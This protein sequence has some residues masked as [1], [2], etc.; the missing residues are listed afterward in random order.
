MS[1]EKTHHADVYDDLNS[2][3]IFV[4]GGTGM[5]GSHVIQK[6][7]K[8]HKKV[9]AI[10]RNV[11][12]TYEGSQKVE[13]CKGDIL[14]IPFLEE[15][16]VNISTVYHCAAIVSFN[17]KNKRELFKIN[18]EGT[19][20]VVNAALLNGVN[21]MCHVS[22]VAALGKPK[23]KE[24][25]ETNDWNDADVKSN[26]SKSK[27]L[28]ELEVWRGI[29]EGMNAVIVNPSI[30]LGAG[31]WDSGSTKIFQ[32]AYNEFPWYTEGVTGFVD[33]HDVVDAMLQ[34]TQ[35]NVTNERFIVSAENKTYQ[36]IF[37]SIATNFG[38]KSPH[39]K[40]TPLLAGVIRRLED[41]KSIFSNKEPLLT[42]ETAEA[43]LA[44]VYYNNEKLLK[45]LPNFS[46]TP[47][48]KTIER[49]C[50]ELKMIYSLA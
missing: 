28:G 40:V 43:A 6:L 41:I 20:N 37:S 29:G 36:N 13:W 21:Q 31:N 32:T 48:D 15:V 33:V 42:K 23:G 7:I 17:P 10:Y 3:S 38:K 1:N 39:K 18:V 49:V 34:L 26:Y 46:Y 47:I 9:K 25:D 12:P 44:S 5:L 14:D 45:L 8:Q 22:S 11:V 16:M 50:K 27:Y 4:T 19:A 24:I 30:I 2:K 35:S